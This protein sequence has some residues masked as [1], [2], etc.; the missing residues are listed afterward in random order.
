MPLYVFLL[1]MYQSPFFYVHVDVHIHV[2]VREDVF[3]MPRF[4]EMLSEEAE[5]VVVQE[6]GRGA[7]KS[8]LLTNV[9]T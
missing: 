6:G 8:C 4:C 1:I 3:G 5:D 2:M 7:V 9:Q